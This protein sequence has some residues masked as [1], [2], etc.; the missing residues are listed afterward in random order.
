[1]INH[2]ANYSDEYQASL[3]SAQESA[4]VLK[5]RGAELVRDGFLPVDWLRHCLTLA[6]VRREVS[7]AE[8]LISQPDASRNTLSDSLRDAGFGSS[9]VL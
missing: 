2:Y 4:D 3:T 5:R 8:A 6:D 1:M 9:G 7:A